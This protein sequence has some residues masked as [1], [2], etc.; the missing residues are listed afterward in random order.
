M[1]PDFPRNL[2]EFLGRFPDEAT[3]AEYVYRSRWPDG[4]ACPKCE[5]MSA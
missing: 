3:C 4:W 5:R 2:P 1:R